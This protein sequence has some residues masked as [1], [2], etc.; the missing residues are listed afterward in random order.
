M[1]I[2]RMRSRL[3]KSGLLALLVLGV[4]TTVVG[5]D[6]VRF[7]TQ[8]LSTNELGVVDGDGHGHANVSIDVAAGLVCF[9]VSFQ[10]SGTPNRAHIHVGNADQN[11]GIVVPFFELAAAPG[12]PRNDELELTG[13]TG[14]CVSADPALLA[15]IVAN[16]SGYYVNLHNARFPPGS[17]RG[18]LDD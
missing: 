8:L 15:Q 10:A 6:A 5:A 7:Q 16:P 1:S 12:D 14:G 4:A 9:D 11:G 2:L 18:Q 3:A 13:R 17:M